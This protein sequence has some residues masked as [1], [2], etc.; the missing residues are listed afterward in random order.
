MKNRDL[1]L[2]WEQQKNIGSVMA[3]LLTAAKLNPEDLAAEPVEDFF[4]AFWQAHP[5]PQYANASY[6]YALHGAKHKQDW[7]ALSKTQKEYYQVFMKHFRA[8]W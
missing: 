3:E 1:K 2:W 5:K 4:M 6:L 8:S 7:L